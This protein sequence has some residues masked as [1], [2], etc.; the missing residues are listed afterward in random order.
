MSEDIETA[1]TEAEEIPQEEAEVESSEKALLEEVD[2]QDTVEE[3]QDSEPVVEVQQVEEF[4][5][6][7]EVAVE[8]NTEFVE[9]V[10]EN[11]SEVLEAEKVSV[12]RNSSGKI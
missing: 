3:S 4:S 9:T 2:N 7:E 10:E 8:E 6:S 1:L 12:R 11:N 5:N